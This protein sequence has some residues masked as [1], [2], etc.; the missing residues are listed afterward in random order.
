MAEVGKL[1]VN[2]IFLGFISQFRASFIVGYEFKRTNNFLT[3]IDE[4]LYNHYT[5]ISQFLLALDGENC[6]DLGKTHFYF[7][8][9]SKS[10][11][12]DTS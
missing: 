7:Y 1:R 2:I 11:Q 5:D 12:Y 8:T 4:T 3:F 6:D 9:Y 10:G